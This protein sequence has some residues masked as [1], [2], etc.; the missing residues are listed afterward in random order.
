MGIA[1]ERTFVPSVA[2]LRIR[3]R[4]LRALPL[5]A[6]LLDLLLVSAAVVLAAYGRSRTLIFDPTN[7]PGLSQSVDGPPLAQ[8]VAFVA[9]PLVIGW[10]VVVALRGGYDRGVF[11]AGA[12]EYKTVV[13]ASL[14]TAALLGIGCYLL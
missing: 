7:A 11:G 9:V 13:N 4:A 12:D 8:S 14:L 1:P 6:L 2:S 10:I 3:S 5:T